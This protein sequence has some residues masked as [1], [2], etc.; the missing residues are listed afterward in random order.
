MAKKSQMTK[1]QWNKL[2]LFAKKFIALK[3]SHADLILLILGSKCGFFIC[4]CGL[5]AK[6]EKAEKLQREL[7]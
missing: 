6:L 4:R 3:E 5:C 2:P 1:G 7:S